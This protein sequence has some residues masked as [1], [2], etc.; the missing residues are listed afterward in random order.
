MKK[1]TD[2]FSPKIKPVHIG[3]YEVSLGR[4][5][6]PPY[7]YW[8]GKRWGLAALSVATATNCKLTAV[9]RQDKSWRGLTKKAV[10]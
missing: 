10:V 2:W 1:Y 4:F 7:A 8:N 6:S 5:Y 3:V 9:A